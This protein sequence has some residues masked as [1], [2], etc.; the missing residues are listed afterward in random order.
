[1]RSM[2]T[3]LLLC[4]TFVLASA[5]GARA[6]LSIRVSEDGGTAALFSTASTTL[7]LVPGSA[8]LLAAA[9]DFTFSGFGATATATSGPLGNIAGTGTIDSTDSS[10]HT[11]T[12][13]VSED[14]FP[15]V[16]TTYQLGSSSGYTSIADPTDSFTFQSFAAPGSVPFG[17]AVSSP[18]HTYNPLILG[19]SDHFDESAKSFMPA[20][21]YTLTQSF[22]W[23]SNSSGD[24]LSLHGSTTA[25]AQ[26]VPEPASLVLFGLGTLGLAE[27]R[28]RKRSA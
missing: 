2:T 8:A 26:A 1:M 17:T 5:A 12:I 25:I 11:L 28:R 10:L 23:T 4:L 21:G 13:L 18:G 22:V 15:S 27:I 6:N 7:N 3:R 20:S 16:A 19:G 24:E 9:P 14:A